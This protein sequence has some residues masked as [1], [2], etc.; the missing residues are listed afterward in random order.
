MVRPVVS[1]VI[2]AFKQA[3][4][5][6]ACLDSVAAQSFRGQVEVIVVDDGCPEGTGDV[7][8]RHPLRPLLVRQSNQ[9]VAA[10]RNAG[11]SRATG[12]Y[13]AFLDA[14]DQ[15]LPD[16]L[17]IQVP[18]LER[19]ARPG[20]GFGQYF[21]IDESGT[22]LPG[23]IHPGRF[24]DANA[25]TL[26][27]G[28]Y[29]GCLTAIVDRRCLED[30]GGFPVSKALQRGGQDYALWLRIALRHPLFYAPHLVGKYVIHS[31]SRVGL[32]AL[33]NFEGALNAI[34]AV[35]ER[36]PELCRRVLSRPYATYVARQ[37]RLVARRLVSER[38]FD[39]GT[40]SRV[41]RAA[42]SALTRDPSIHHA[43]WPAPLTSE[44]ST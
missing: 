39:R 7:A 38:E 28:N 4:L 21:T 18:Q 42:R 26:F 6:P 19:S 2:P 22:P 34:A 25:E 44:E 30:V 16:K 37:V 13:V 40:W 12:R 8:A 17:E 27:Q 23:G 36:D 31:K 24:G 32:D 14:D 35:W 33:K 29:I 10:A 1:V 41:A 11:M 9:G 43:S 5:I 15:W 3:K 20:L